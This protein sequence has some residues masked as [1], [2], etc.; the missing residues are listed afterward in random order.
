MI[1]QSG[2]FTMQGKLDMVTSV[3]DPG[4]HSKQNQMLGSRTFG[5]LPCTSLFNV[6][7][8]VAQEQIQMAYE[9]V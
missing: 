3:N 5:F 6:N 9:C 1:I 8:Q 7:I 4:T 2:F